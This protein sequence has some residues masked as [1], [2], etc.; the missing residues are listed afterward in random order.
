MLTESIKN[1]TWLRA[2][3]KFHSY[4]YRDPRVAFATAVGL[5][6]VSPTTVLLGIVSTLFRVGLSDDAKSFLEIVHKCEV[7]VDAPEGVIF[8][9][10][11]HQLRRYETNAMKVSKEKFKP[12]PRIGL[13]KINQGTREYGVVDGNMTVFVGV[14]DNHLESVKIALMN[15][16]HLG[17]HDSLCSI[18]GSVEACAE[19]SHIMYMPSE[20]LAKRIHIGDMNLLETGVTIVTLSVFK[21]Q[22]QPVS[23]YWWLSG[24][25]DTELLS[26]AIPGKFEGTSRG[27]IYRKT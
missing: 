1:T 18:D 9:R 2:S 5:P 7:V 13:T 8:F 3:Y 22:I 6:V 21:N 23:E 26:Y 19:P 11:F 15:L 24:G 16:T 25:N 10:A 17:T 27:K 12:N 14:P 4:S 20:E